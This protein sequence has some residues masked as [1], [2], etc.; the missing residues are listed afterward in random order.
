MASDVDVGPDIIKYISC[1]A[2]SFGDPNYGWLIKNVFFFP[3]SI[4]HFCTI[5]FINKV[6]WKRISHSWLHINQNG[7][8]TFKLSL[9]PEGICSLSEPTALQ[10]SF[11]ELHR[12][13]PHPT[14]SVLLS[15][16]HTPTSPALLSF[17]GAP[18]CFC[19]HVALS[20]EHSWVTETVI[21][22]LF[23]GTDS[24]DSFIQ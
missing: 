1:W 11:N 15:F 21:H 12:C 18:L 8:C 16:T 13:C 20:T 4:L 24:L 17:N 5:S 9:Q 2:W 7:R 23:K 6:F 10:G 3:N 22:N 14:A 19:L